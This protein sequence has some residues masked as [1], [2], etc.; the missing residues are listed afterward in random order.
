VTWEPKGRMTRGISRYV[1]TRALS[2]LHWNRT[3]K[4]SYFICYYVCI[5]R[6]ESLVLIWIWVSQY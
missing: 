4:I 5:Y 3:R 2:F 6:T 1:S